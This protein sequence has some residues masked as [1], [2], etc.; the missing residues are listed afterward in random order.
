MPYKRLLIGDYDYS[1]QFIMTRQ[2][3]I[4][5]YS[6]KLTP[7]PIYRNIRHTFAEVILTDDKKVR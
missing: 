3:N 4:L 2:E 7:M 1:E 5:D 6:L